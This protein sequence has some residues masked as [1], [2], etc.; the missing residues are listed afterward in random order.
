MSDDALG[1]LQFVLENYQQDNL[2]D[3]NNVAEQCPLADSVLADGVT[4]IDKNYG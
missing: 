1:E 2:S 3:Q 4:G